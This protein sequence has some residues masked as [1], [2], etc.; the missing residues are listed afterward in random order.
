MKSIIVLSDTHARRKNLQKITPLFAENDMIIH[1]GDGSLDMLE[2]VKNY[3]EKTYVCQGN[4]DLGYGRAEYVLEVEGVRI[5]CCHGH[6]YGVKSGLYKL[7][8]CAKE[9]DCSVALYG[10]THE[11][12]IDEVDGVLCINP[13]SL[14]EWVES[15]YAYLAVHRNKVTPVLVKI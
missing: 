11:A 2:T 1:L 4:C 5:F 13:G 12:R 6:R 8:L 15:G 3:P 14:G 9:N 10:H 7:A